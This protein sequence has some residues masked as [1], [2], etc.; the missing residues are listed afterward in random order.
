MSEV[1]NWLATTTAKPLAPNLVPGAIK[2]ERR[3][4]GALGGLVGELLE[5]VPPTWPQP[6]SRWVANAETPPQAAVAE[7]RDRISNPADVFATLYEKVVSGPNRRRLGTFFTPPEVV[8]LMLERAAAML[9][10]PARIVDPGAGVG[11]FSVAA[12]KWWPDATVCAI[13]VNLVTLGLLATRLALEGQAEQVDLVLED[14]L[15]WVQADRSPGPRLFLGNPPYTR[16]QDLDQATKRRATQASGDLV[17]STLAGLAAYF[18]AASLNHLRPEDALSFVLPGSW[19]EARHGSGIRRWLWE[20]TRRNVELLAFP[21]DA[22]IFPGT[23]VNAV[24]VTVGPETDMTATFETASIRP[25]PGCVVLGKRTV[26]ER[27]R[28]LPA[29]F[30]PM[31]WKTTQGAVKGTVALSELG[32][33]KRGVATGANHWFFLT[34]VE[35]RGLPA[36]L[37]RR[38]VQRLRDIDGT[39][40]DK[41]THD[42]LRDTGRRRWLLTLAGPADCKPKAVRDLIAAGEAEGYHE[43]YLTRIRDHWYAVEPATAPHI[44]VT[45]MSKD[46]FRAV[47]NEVGAIPS[48]SMYG[49][50]L[51]DPAVAGPLCRWLNSGAGQAAI[52]S[53][54]RHYSDGLLKLEPRDYQAVRVPAALPA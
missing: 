54:A 52:R 5:A 32:R 2:E 44:I 22:E 47:L 38:A 43:R 39:V 1:A 46:T 3:R 10:A 48:N 45:L 11:A 28:A 51:K 40:L 6:L 15:P 8:D 26:I 35:A 12:A 36:R 20:Q 7:V 30:G 21:S 19:T 23:R 37:L 49:I 18:L 16:H 13:D 24:I 31:L 34:D 17:D 4:L 50:H 9:P 29:S 25:A 41:A 27:S 42:R 33:V 53:C 14:Y